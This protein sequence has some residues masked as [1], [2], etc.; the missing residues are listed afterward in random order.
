MNNLTVGHL[1]VVIRV[2]QLQQVFDLLLPLNHL[3]LLNQLSKLR[4][5]Q[6]AVIIRINRLENLRKSQQEL[7][8]LL[9]LKIKNYLLKIRITNFLILPIH[10]LLIDLLPRHLPITAIQVLL[11]PR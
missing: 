1:L 6:N 8:V 7:L 11:L 5:I 10:I 9:Q 2:H 4:L 3:H